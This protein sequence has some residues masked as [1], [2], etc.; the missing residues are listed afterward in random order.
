MSTALRPRKRLYCG[1]VIAALLLAPSP[2]HAQAAPSCLAAFDGLWR[3][4]GTILNRPVIMEQ[5]WAPALGGSFRE[6]TMRHLSAKDTVTVGFEGRGF[7]RLSGATMQGSWLDARG[8]IFPV[9]GNCEAGVLTSD[10]GGPE[11]R[12]RGRT[13][14]RL[15][16]VTELEVIDSVSMP[17]GSRREFGRSKLMKK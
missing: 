10:W 16:S 3:G 14:Y 9:T 1:C 7:Y 6:L 2:G 17:D 5:R 8:L 13:V 4:S 11:S 15:L 12:E